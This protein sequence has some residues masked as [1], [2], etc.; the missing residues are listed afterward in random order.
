VSAG[1]GGETLASA[2][3]LCLPLAHIAMSAALFVGGQSGFTASSISAEFSK[4]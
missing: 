4:P 1:I 3:A 2:S